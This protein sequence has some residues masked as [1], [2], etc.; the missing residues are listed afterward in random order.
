M[1]HKGCDS[2]WVA[3]GWKLLMIVCNLLGVGVVCAVLHARPGA[4]AS[5]LA[6]LLLFAMVAADGLQEQALCVP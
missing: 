6:P 2:E 1:T 3:S 5:T 4:G